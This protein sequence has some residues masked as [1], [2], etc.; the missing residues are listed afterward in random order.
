[1][2]KSPIK[3]RRFQSN[4][5]GQR[6]PM[7]I[8]RG[9]YYADWRDAKGKRFRK[10]FDSEGLAMAYEEAQKALKRGKKMGQEVKGSANSLARNRR[11]AGQQIGGHGSSLLKSLATSNLKVSGPSIAPSSTRVSNHAANQPS[12]GKHGQQPFAKRLSR[13]GK[14]TKPHASMNASSN[15]QR[16][17]LGTSPLRPPRG[18]R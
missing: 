14:T 2:H 11:Q 10:S 12:Q 7:Y 15:R 1:M 4:S 5:T 16:R 8:E 6:C 9:K 3:T 18:Q 13:S 17:S